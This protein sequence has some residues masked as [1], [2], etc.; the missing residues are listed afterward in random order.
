MLR[1]DAAKL[2]NAVGQYYGSMSRAGFG[3]RNAFRPVLFELTIADFEILH[4]VGVVENQ[5]VSGTR[6]KEFLLYG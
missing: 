5:V 4:H 1:E 3:A 2:V 6:L